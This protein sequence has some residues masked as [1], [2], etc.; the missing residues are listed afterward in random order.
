MRKAHY[1]SEAV[2]FLAEQEQVFSDLSNKFNGES[3]SSLDRPINTLVHSIVGQQISVAAANAI[4]LRMKEKFGDNLKESVL[5]G[6]VESLRATGLSRQKISYLKNIF[7]DEQ[8]IIKATECSRDEAYEILIKIKGIGP[9]TAEMFLIFC[10]MDSD[11]FPLKD[12]GLRNAMKKYF[13]A[14]DESQML[15]RAESWR[16][17]RTVATWLLWRALDP[18]PV[19]Y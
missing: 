9:W 14:K 16:P 15:K 7:T 1:W 12:V 10:R 13:N 6:D 18:V 3:L 5:S 2:L 17:Y 8:D 19:Q 11:E 4:L